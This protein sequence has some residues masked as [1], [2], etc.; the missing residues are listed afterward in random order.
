MGAFGM[1]Y[2]LWFVLVSNHS[3]KCLILV[4]LYSVFSVYSV[5]T[6]DKITTEYTENTEKTI[7]REKQ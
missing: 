4:Q 7:E 6:A 5:V 2:K 3:E 1:S